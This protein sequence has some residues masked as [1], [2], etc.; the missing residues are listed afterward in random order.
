[1]ADR[2]FDDTRVQRQALRLKGKGQARGI[3]LKRRKNGGSWMDT[4]GDMVTLLLTFFVCL[5]SMSSIS[6]LQWT[7]IVRAF[8]P[9]ASHRVDQIVFAVTEQE[10]NAA[11]EN[12]AN[13]DKDDITD[14]NKS[15]TLPQQEIIVFE[16]LYNLLSD[17]ISNSN[18]SDSIRLEQDIETLSVYL[19][20]DNTILFE[21]D[22]SDLLPV[23]H[24]PLNIVGQA[25][26]QNEK[27]IGKVV[28]KGYTADVESAADA[29]QLS[30]NRALNI[31]N[32]FKIEKSF[33]EEKLMFS[34]FGHLYP[35]APNDNAVDRAKNRRVEI[36]INPININDTTNDFDGSYF[37][38]KENVSDS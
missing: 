1:M 28:I 38:S 34:G 19:Q 13:A 10:G 29:W 8:N 5:Y 7:E 4:Y 36:V 25:L 33:P 31:L 20:F 2:G 16:N 23:S 32:F 27:Y 9:T 12:H 11:K 26:V 24:E 35:I 30:A 22:K 17:Y 21:P 37:A 15:E 6:E 14:N 18:V 3:K